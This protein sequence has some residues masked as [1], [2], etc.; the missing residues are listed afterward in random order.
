MSGGKNG[1]AL[2]AV[3]RAIERHSGA[4]LVELL[5]GLQPSDKAEIL[6]SLSPPVRRAA[7]ALL[8]DGEAAVILEEMEYEFQADVLR[9]LGPERSSRI[10]QNM[11][12]DDA[13]DILGSLPNREARRILEYMDPENS[14]EIAG[15]MAFGKDTAGGIMTTE[16]V[17]IEEDVTVGQAIEYIR[18]RAQEAETVY[19]AYVVSSAGELTGV[20]SFRELLLADRD[21]KIRD[22]MSRRVISVTTD[23]DQEEVAALVAKYN[24]LAIPVVDSRGVLKGIVTFDDA[25]DILSEEATEDILRFSGNPVPTE[26]EFHLTAWQKA[27]KRLPWLIVLLFGELIAGSVIHFSA[28]SSEILAALAVFV[29]VMTGE[30]G[31]AA[32]QSLAVVVRGLATGEMRAREMWSIVLRE[33]RT[34]MLVG[35][36]CGILLWLVVVLSQGNTIA[37]LVAGLALAANMLVACSLGALF[38][39]IIK[40]IGFDPAVASGPFITTLTDVVSMFI[41]FTLAGLFLAPLFRVG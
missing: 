13:A 35:V 3:L 29:P 34:G 30:A 25:M 10:L 26:Q 22:I 19:Y 18:Q 12:A 38:P 2:E 4:E 1:R 16:F 24:F 11:S 6:E 27:R 23:T 36:P 7:F 5:T 15:L 20:L 40:R 41:Y 21:V 32:T 33:S 8:S 14:S 17:A 37:G 31:N 28:V 39:V 9:E